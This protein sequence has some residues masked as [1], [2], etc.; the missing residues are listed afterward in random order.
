M[1][2]EHT[3]PPRTRAQKQDEQ[4]EGLALTPPNETGIE[5]ASTTATKLKSK[6]MRDKEE[7]SGGMK[8]TAKPKSKQG[9]GTDEEEKKTSSMKLKKTR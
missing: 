7:K 6:Q 2:C 8:T 4:E 3:M 9:K 1:N 5:K